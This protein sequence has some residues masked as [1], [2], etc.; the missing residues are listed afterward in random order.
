MQYTVSLSSAE[1]EYLSATKGVQMII[2]K[3]NLM[4]EMTNKTI[5]PSML[6]EDNE[7]CIFIIKNR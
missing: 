5:T 7:G 1:A 6:L 3:N 2:F 4:N